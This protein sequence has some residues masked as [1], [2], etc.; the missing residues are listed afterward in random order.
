VCVCVCVCVCVH[1]C[2]CIEDRGQTREAPQR[3]AFHTG[4]HRASTTALES[5][6]DGTPMCIMG[7]KLK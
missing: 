3:L 5:Q 6:A 2:L 1:V 7:T 4:T